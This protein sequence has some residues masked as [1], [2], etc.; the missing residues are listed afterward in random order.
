MEIGN[1][2]FAPEYSTRER[3]KIICKYLLIFLP[4]FAA[5][6]WWF[7][8]WFNEYVEV[9][10]CYNYSE[11]TGTHLVFYGLFVGMP[12]FLF[13]GLFFTEGI[14]NI[15]VFS[16]GQHP[17]PGEKVFKA[18]RYT[19]GRSAKIKSLPILFLLVAILGFSI[20]GFSAAN[21]IISMVEQKGL[22]CIN[23]S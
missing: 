2:E 17:L 5:T 15:R 12:L 10:H 18:T 22:S 19:Y 11:F 9:A 23:S 8:P 6:K 7:F 16:L 4:L 3:V 1:N 14:K 13:L 20:Y 21:D